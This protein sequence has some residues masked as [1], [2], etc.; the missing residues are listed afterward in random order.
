MPTGVELTEGQRCC[1]QQS[2]LLFIVLGRRSRRP[3]MS[4]IK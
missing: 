2:D 1:D 4:L 3:K